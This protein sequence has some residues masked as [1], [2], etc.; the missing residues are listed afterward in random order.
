M[1]FVLII[2]LFL[3]GFSFGQN[4][5]LKNFTIN[6]GTVSIQTNNGTYL[7]R[8]YDEN[9]IETSFLGSNDDGIGESHAIIAQPERKDISVKRDSET[10]IPLFYLTGAAYTNAISFSLDSLPFKIRYFCK[11]VPIVQQ[12]SLLTKDQGYELTLGVSEDEALYG[13]GARA[14]GM[15]RRGNKLELY[16]RAHYGYETNAPLMNYCIPMYLSSKGYAVHFDAPGTGWLDLDSEGA[17]QVQFETVSTRKTYQLVIGDDWSDVLENWTLI[18]GRQPKL[19]IWALGN[20]ASRFGYHS[21]SEVENLVNKFKE[22]EIPL[23]AVVLDLYWFGKTIKGTMGNL[24]F[25]RDSFP[26]PEGMIGNLRDQNIKTVL[27]TEPFVLTTSNRWQ[28]AVDNN[29]LA[30][31]ASGKPLTYNFYFGNT[32]LIDVFDE[33]AGNWFWSKYFELKQMGVAGFWGDLGEPEVHPDEMLHATGTAREVHNIYGHKWAQLVYEG[34]KETY[35]EERP[36]ILMRSGSS[37]SQRF[38]MIPWSGDVNRTWGGLRSQPEI[39]LQMGMQGIPY[40]HSDLGGF[41]GDNDDPELYTRWLQYGVFQPIFRPHA[42]EE[43]ASEPVFKDDQTKALAKQSI[44]L[45][46]RLLPYNYTLMCEASTK[47]TPLMRP[48]FFDPN[49]SNGKNYK[50]VDS[51]YLWGDAFLVAP[52]LV[53]GQKDK[54]I[55][56]P[57]GSNWF[58]FYSKDYIKSGSSSRFKLSMDHIPTFIR[59]ESFVPM[60]ENLQSTSDYDPKNVVIHYYSDP[61]AQ[62]GEGNFEYDSGGDQSKTNIPEDQVRFVSDWNGK[63]GTIKA[64]S[65]FGNTKELDFTL[66]FW[67]SDIIK[68]KVNG[69]K[70]KIAKGAKSVELSNLNVN[71]GKLTIWMKVKSVR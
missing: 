67:S 53:K 8:Y 56:F 12:E 20:F 57:Q 52:V 55:N 18:S 31:D 3:A 71:K 61:S 59:G 51:V 60:V 29:A 41:A 43:V 22:E 32:G 44:E 38:G 34:L 69:K 13:G 39:A 64:T 27:V 10:G 2:V 14:L 1:K 65:E 24:D 42:Q 30:K 33:N 15:N 54:R 5:V 45:R 48:V 6:D 37:G 16:N 23:D 47:G 58:D 25:Y 40:M 46:Y 49:T 7:I 19:P 63:K 17:N 11:N 9:V 70:V 4:E 68:I 66:H 35:P 62:S 26:D 50:E 36:F 21:Q 28:E